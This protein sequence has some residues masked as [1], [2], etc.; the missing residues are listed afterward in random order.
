MSFQGRTGAEDLV[1]PR[2]ISSFTAF[3]TGIAIQ[4]FALAGIPAVI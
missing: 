3:E 2:L 4:E 1:P